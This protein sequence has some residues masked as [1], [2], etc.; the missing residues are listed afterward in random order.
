[1]LPSSMSNALK[2]CQLSVFDCCNVLLEPSYDVN[3]IVI[4]INSK[5]KIYIYTCSQLENANIRCFDLR[6]K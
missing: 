3:D 5:K 6:L 4:S 2:F 1:M